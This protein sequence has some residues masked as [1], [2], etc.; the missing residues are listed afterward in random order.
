MELSQM[1]NRWIPAAAVRFLSSLRRPSSRG[2]FRCLTTSTFALAFATSSVAALAQSFT[3]FAP[4]GATTTI[5]TGINSAGVVTGWYID[6]SGTHGFLRDAAGNITPFDPA[7]S[8]GTSAQ[9][10]NANGVTTGWYGTG[11]AFHGFVRDA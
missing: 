6:R 9:G 3:T 1:P 11:T 8:T 5:P 10:I 4:P 2:R 7:G